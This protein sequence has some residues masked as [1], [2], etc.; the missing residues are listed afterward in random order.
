[1]KRILR[2]LFFWD[3]PA[4]GAFFALTFFFV[5]SS[6]WFTLFQMIW[7]S[8]CGLVQFNIMSECTE[9]E[10][11]VWAGVELL[12]ALYSLIVFCR[13][14]WL[15]AVNC[16]RG[17]KYLP[18]ICVLGSMALWLC[19]G[20]FC[21][22]VFLYFYK[23]FIYILLGEIGSSAPAFL[24]SRMFGLAYLVAVLCMV[25]GGFCAVKSF[26][27]AEGKRLRTAVSKAGVALWGVFGVAYLVFLGMALMQSRHVARARALVEQRFGHPLTADGLREVY[28]KKGPTDAE[29]WKR[30]EEASG[31]ITAKFTIGDKTLEYWNRRLPETLTPEVLSAFD[32]YCKANEATII[33]MEKCF[34]SIPPLPSYEFEAGNLINTILV[35]A[36]PCRRFVVF[37]LSRMRVFLKR[38][39]KA[40]ALRSYQRIDNCAVS[41]QYTPFLIGGLVCLAVEGYR[42]DAIERL[43][44]SRMLS[45]DDL[46]RLS[47]DLDALEK[48]VPA[49]H[50]QAMYSE[51]TFGQDVLWGLER[52]KSHEI[53]MAF[54]DLRFFYPQLWFHVALDK[55]Y[56]LQQY[57]AED[58][59]KMSAAPPR[60]GSGSRHTPNDF[61][62]KQIMNAAFIFSRMLIPSLQK[63]GNKFH[64]MTARARAMKALLKADAY[65]REHGDYPETIADL[66]TDPFTGKPMLYRYGDVELSEYVLMRPETF[67]EDDEEDAKRLEL[68]PQTKTARAVQIWSVGPNGIDEGGRHDVTVGGKDDFSARIR[69]E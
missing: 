11:Q 49:L 59:S 67:N 40:E 57:L 1:M 47:A 29:F 18:L 51:A 20:L 19:G 35:N 65:R 2:K 26:V 3:S 63:A 48:R 10:V 46:Q 58:F 4:K 9:R 28:S 56:I 44:E 5:V 50:Q 37:E 38:Q 62:D 25:A 68:M 14:L 31:K 39:D 23:S 27:S 66:P 61:G 16:R 12:I 43:L 34:E 33:E 8:D 41:L 55:E 6:L 64:G 15:L 21:L 24:P 42:L 17:R 53:H 13:A 45:D 30:L 7:L 22:A 32:D 69:L 60:E 52:G 36:S 54:G